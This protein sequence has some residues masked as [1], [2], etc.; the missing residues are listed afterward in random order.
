MDFRVAS[1][2]SGGTA[3]LE[4]DGSPVTGG[5]ALPDTG[6][7]NT[8]ATLTATG[9]TLPAGA[10]VLRVVFETDGMNVDWIRFAN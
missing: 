7:W 2:G 4:I 5:I 9:V 6:G 1:S 3:H 8:W 10:H